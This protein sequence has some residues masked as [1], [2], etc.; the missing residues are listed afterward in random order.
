MRE[1]EGAVVVGG[2]AQES[3]GRWAQSARQQHDLVKGL[4]CVVCSDI[5]IMRKRMLPVYGTHA[6]V[7]ATPAL[8]TEWRRGVWRAERREVKAGAGL[9]SRCLPARV[10]LA[11]R[12]YCLAKSDVNNQI[13]THRPSAPFFL[14][15][16]TSMLLCVQAQSRHRRQSM[17]SIACIGFTIISV[18][19]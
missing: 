4:C 16:Q 8:G 10:R 7:N 18:V 9:Q 2:K 13:N 1:K 19:S 11:L 15:Y 17:S 3:G 14:R 5:I 6:R 12:R